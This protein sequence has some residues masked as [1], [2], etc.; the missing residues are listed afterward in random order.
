M[1]VGDL[2]VVHPDVNRYDLLARS[3]YL[4]V[5]E[6]HTKRVLKA[7]AQLFRPYAWH[8][9]TLDAF[10]VRKYGKRA[11]NLERLYATLS[12]LKEKPY[13]IVHCH[14]GGQGLVGLELLEQGVIT[15]KLVTS[16]RGADIT[17]TLQAHP[18]LY[19]QLVKKG[20]LFLPISEFFK[21]KLISEGCDPQKIAVLRDGIDLSRFTFKARRRAADE[22]TRLLS[23]RRASVTTSGFTGGARKTRF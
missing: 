7:S 23:V 22:P 9:A 5:P 6:D 19:D 13:D 1:S 4:K 3:R 20:D 15:G 8:L 17:S 16:I 12:F 21:D 2:N 18:G 10:N 11:L 14:F